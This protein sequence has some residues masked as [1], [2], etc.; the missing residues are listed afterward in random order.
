M[1]L[2]LDTNAFINYYN[3]YFGEADRLSQETRKFIDLCFDI[4]DEKYRLSIPSVVFLEIFDKFL[5]T[6]EKRKEFYYSIFSPLKNKEKIEIKSIERGV[7][8]QFIGTSY[9][10]EMHDRIIY[11]S[12]KEINAVLVTSDSKIIE[13][14]N[15]AGNPLRIIY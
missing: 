5:N 11:C 13:C 3:D 10:L 6:Q 14:N 15:L 2:V 4:Y 8:E 7:I 12:A 1:L 9:K